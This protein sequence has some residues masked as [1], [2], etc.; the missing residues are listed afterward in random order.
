MFDQSPRVATQRKLAE[1]MTTREAAP[2]TKPTMQTKGAAFHD[3]SV[4]EKE[5]VVMGGQAN[6]LKRADI[7]NGEQSPVQM[8]KFERFQGKS[9]LVNWFYSE[10][11]TKLLAE[12]KRVE[13]FLGLMQPY[14]ETRYGEILESI[15][16]QFDEIKTSTYAQDDYPTILKKLKTLYTELDKLSTSIALDEMNVYGEENQDLI[17][18]RLKEDLGPRAAKLLAIITGTIDKM[19][20]LMRTAKNTAVVKKALYPDIENGGFNEKLIS[21]H[22]LSFAKSRSALLLKNF[23]ALITRVMTDWDEITDEFG[24]TGIPKYIHLT[25]SD[26][27]KGGQQVAIIE[28]T[29]GGEVVYKPRSVSP[30]AGLVGEGGFFQQFNVLSDKTVELPTMKFLEK[31]DRDLTSYAYVEFQEHKTEKSEAEVEQYYRRYGQMVIASKLLG[32]TDLHHEN[33][34]A[35]AG[36]P[37]IIDAETSFIPYIMSAVTFAKTEIADALDRFKDE[38]KLANTAF[39]TPEEQKRWETMDKE[40][41]KEYSGIYAYYVSAVRRNDLAG[42]G[43]YLKFFISGLKDML[44]LIAEKK[45]EI[46][47]MMLDQI[48]TLRHIRIVPFGTIGFSGSLRNFRDSMSEG[49]VEGADELVKFDVKKVAEALEG[50]GFKLLSDAWVSSTD[51]VVGAG[52]KKDYEMGD[53]PIFHFE[54]DKNELIYH[55]EVVGMHTEWFNPEELIIKTVKSVAASDI[56]KILRNLGIIEEI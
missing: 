23:R 36:T 4:L 13:D 43:N 53:T 31:Q 48:K 40:E 15:E 24:L 14:K 25:G 22:T 18:A 5:A 19:P 35:V 46:I 52:L 54:P 38:E 49:D 6:Q 21:E 32:V 45:K 26:F 42:K 1:V 27:H 10:T 41:R 28:S 7:K 16:E 9:R 2:Q 39:V 30:D 8:M 51:G 56:D 3:D 55:D 50:K 44:Q 17:N 11:E 29:D 34:M 37:T 12:E 47:E 20:E 33:I